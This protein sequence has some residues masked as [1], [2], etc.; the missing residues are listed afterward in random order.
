LDRDPQHYDG[1]PPVNVLDKIA[2]SHKTKHV[3]SLL[4]TSQLF[5]VSNVL[6]SHTIISNKTVRFLTWLVIA[7]R[8]S[9]VSTVPL[10]FS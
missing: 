8:S 7:E 10:I 9:L 1:S 4:S 2:I 6:S 5:T 3:G